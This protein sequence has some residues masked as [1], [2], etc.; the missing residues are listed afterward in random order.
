MMSNIIETQDGSHTLFSTQFGESYHS[1]YGAIQESRHVFISAGL[2]YLIPLHKSISIL[3][4][5]FGSGLNALLTIL[6]CRQRSL[7]L[8]YDTIEAYPV[9][10]FDALQL[11][12][13]T[14]LDLTDAAPLFSRLHECSWEAWHNLFADINFRKRQMQIQ[15][16]EEIAQYD[17]VYYDAFGPGAQP[18]LWESSVLERV[19]HALK[20]GGVFVTYCAKG[21]VKR[22]LRGLGFQVEALPGP[23]GKR[24][25]TRAIKS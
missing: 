25:M 10:A 9:D 5:G 7:S 8:R 19:Y 16:L 22:I 11:N 18:E 1:R 12:Y 23:P 2:F 21:S 3:E 6:E 13:P 17:L 24:E 20:P 14:Q 4:M 15:Q